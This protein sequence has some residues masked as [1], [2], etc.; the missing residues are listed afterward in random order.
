MG[1][2]HHH[3]HEDQLPKLPKFAGQILFI[4][5]VAL[6][7]S[8]SL[9]VYKKLI[10]MASIV[11]QQED[12]RKLRNTCKKDHKASKEEGKVNW[13]QAMCNCIG[14]EMAHNFDQDVKSWIK[15]TSR[16]E[17]MAD[18]FKSIQACQE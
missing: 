14:R 5:I 18:Y 1:H 2:H 8:V 17:R 6:L 10:P 4:A 16:E 15:T 7:A 11:N 3:D 12:V 13:D 9:F